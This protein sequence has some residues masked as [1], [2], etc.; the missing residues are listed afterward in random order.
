MKIETL[1]ITSTTLHDEKRAVIPP[2]YLSTTFERKEDGTF[3]KDDYIYNRLDNPNR[4]M[5]EKSL[6]VLEKGYQA[7]TFAS[8]LAAVNAVFQTLRTGDHV[9]LPDDAYYAVILLAEELFKDFGITSTRVNQAQIENVANAIT[10]QTRLIWLETPSNPQLRMADISVI[11]KLAKQANALCVV[12]NTW[13]TPIWQNPLR[14]GA[15]IVMHSTTKYFGGHSDLLGGALVI[16]KNE[17]LAEKLRKIQKVGGAVPSPFDCWL[18]ARGIRT[19]PLRVKAQTASATKLAKFL[20]THSAIELVHY[21]FLP[22]HAQYEIAKKQMKGA[23]AMLSIEVNGG[24]EAAMKIANKLKLFAHA[25]SLGGVESLIE[26]RKSIEGAVSQTPDSLLRIS[27]GLEHPADLIA[28]FKQ[29]LK[30]V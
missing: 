11:A 6:T 13:A 26:H 2:I 14:L 19:M 9:I 17:I 8:G 23:G 30:Y 21:P 25:T 3:D 10:P 28:D 20:A 22:S 24:R 16:N 1:A 4:R 27:V 12:D 18:A 7:F 15:D 5:L 29:A